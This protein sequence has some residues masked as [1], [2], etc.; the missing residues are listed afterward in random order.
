[1]P[2]ILWVLFCFQETGRSDP[3]SGSMNLRSLEAVRNGA[4]EREQM[5][6]SL[7]GDRVAAAAARRAAQAIHEKE[8]VNRFNRFMHAMAE[9]AR[10]YDQQH[11]VDVKRLKV[12]KQTL[13]DL[14]DNDEWFKDLRRK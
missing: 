4:I 2:W 5:R 3:F 6:R 8:F 9:F 14:E 7:T 1:M 13:R 11:A 12:V 10:A